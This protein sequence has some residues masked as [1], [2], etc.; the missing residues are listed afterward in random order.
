MIQWLIELNTSMLFYFDSIFTVATL[1]VVCGVVLI[2]DAMKRG[3][4]CVF[5]H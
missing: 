3:L 2:Y 5:S 1:L 4:Y